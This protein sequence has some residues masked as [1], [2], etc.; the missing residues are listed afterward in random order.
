MLCGSVHARSFVARSG[1]S[2]ATMSILGSAVAV[3]TSEYPGVTLDSPSRWTY[4]VDIPAAV[5]FLR[6]F[7]W[8]ATIIVSE[9]CRRRSRM[10]VL[11]ALGGP[12]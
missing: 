6:S 5:E 4:A 10:A 9:G 1:K 3:A 7:I 11:Y 8:A 12:L 2:V